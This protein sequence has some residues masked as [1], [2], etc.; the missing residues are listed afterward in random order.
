MVMEIKPTQGQP[1][2]F[3]KREGLGSTSWT[4]TFTGPTFN[5]PFGARRKRSGFGA[6]ALPSEY[7]SK[8]R[9]DSVTQSDIAEGMIPGISF[10]AYLPVKNTSIPQAT[11]DSVFRTV[12]AQQGFDVSGSTVDSS[13][14]AYQWKYDPEYKVWEA[15]PAAGPSDYVR[16][17]PTAAQ[18]TSTPLPKDLENA[19]KSVIVYKLLLRPKDLSI[20]PAK[21]DTALAGARTGARNAGWTGVLLAADV[22]GVQPPPEA[23]K[24]L[25]ASIGPWIGLIGVGWLAT[26]ALGKQER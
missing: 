12:F 19:P 25:M 1:S 24:P 5:A 6:V 13:A 10:V 16:R 15:L 11:L 7:V 26:L 21:V 3:R 18:T 17:A 23:P 8:T 14:I 20:S 9:A 22:R 2:L 4:S